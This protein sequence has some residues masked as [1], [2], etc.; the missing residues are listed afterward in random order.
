MSL[1]QLELFEIEDD[2]SEQLPDNP[3][4]IESFEIKPYVI[5]QKVI[6]LPLDKDSLDIED[7]FYLKEFEKKRGLI[8]RV[9]NDSEKLCYT[10]DFGTKQ[11]IFYHA[12]LEC[13]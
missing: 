5:E 2:I 11:G 9:H 6:V 13:C 3:L 8:I 4:E 12:D 10:V 7:Y 1:T